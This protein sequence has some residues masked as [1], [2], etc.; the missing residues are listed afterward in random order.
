M[1]YSEN[2]GK[3]KVEFELNGGEI[4]FGIFL[5]KKA[6]LAETS[7]DPFLFSQGPIY[8]QNESGI[9]F[10]TCAADWQFWSLFIGIHS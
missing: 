3:P 1:K 8:E 10:S 2:S 5:P 7:Y 6:V 9:N 4:V